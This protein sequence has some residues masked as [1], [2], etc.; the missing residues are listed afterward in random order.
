MNAAHIAFWFLCV[1]SVAL[2]AVCVFDAWRRDRASDRM[3][4]AGIR[5]DTVC[6]ETD[7]GDV[8]VICDCGKFRPAH[9]AHGW[10]RGRS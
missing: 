7:V 4:A 9:R 1:A 6:A 3:R 10:R 5:G 8:M 2:V